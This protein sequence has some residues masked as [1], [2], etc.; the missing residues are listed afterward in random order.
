M[1][2]KLHN[3]LENIEPFSMPIKIVNIS[4]T[5]LVD[6]GTTCS[7]LNKSLAAQIVSR[8]PY[9]ICV[10]KINKPQL[11]KFLSELIQIEVKIQTPKTYVSCLVVADGLKPL[12]GRDLSDQLGHAVTKSSSEQGDQKNIS[13]HSAFNEIIALHFPD[14][15]S[16]T[17]R[18]KN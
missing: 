12:Y 13:P 17:G 8:N 6:S 4:T 9:A 15:I 18:S 7:I 2:A 5:L 14:L 1:V 3:Y 11:Q 10:C 16:R